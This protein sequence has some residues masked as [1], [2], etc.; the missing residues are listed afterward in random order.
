MTE[1]EIKEIFAKLDADGMS[2]ANIPAVVVLRP[3]TITGNGEIDARE[4]R[5]ALESVGLP[6][7]RDAIMAVIIPMD[8][9]AS[10]SCAS[11]DAKL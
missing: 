4:V 7:D 5:A 1:D 6:H 3:R 8:D 11:N 2:F 10:V 9:D